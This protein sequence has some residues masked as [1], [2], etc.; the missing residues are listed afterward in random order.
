L[1]M[2]GRTTN[3]HS[4]NRCTK[5]CFN[6][7]PFRPLIRP[8]NKTC[9]ERPLYGACVSRVRSGMRSGVRSGRHGGNGWDARS[10]QRVCCFR[11]E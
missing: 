1:T 11:E 9:V 2:A 7:G 10:G 5:N 8:C 4:C 3:F 6:H